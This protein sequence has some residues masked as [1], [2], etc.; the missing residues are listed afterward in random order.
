MMYLCYRVF[1]TTCNNILIISLWS[2]YWLRKLEYPEKTTDLLQ[3]TGKVFH[4]R[5]YQV[6][7]SISGHQTPNLSDERH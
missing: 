6:Y 7:H 2:I 5:L 3:V 1:N 4:I